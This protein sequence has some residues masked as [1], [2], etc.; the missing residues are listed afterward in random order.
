M[1]ISAVMPLMSVYRLPYGQLGYKGHIINLPQNVSAFASTLPRLPTELDIITVRKQGAKNTH[2]DF[3]VRKL[4]VLHALQWLLNN[5]KYYR[6]INL[7]MRA[8]DL[9]PHDGDITDKCT[10]VLDDSSLEQHASNNTE[11]SLPSLGSFIPVVARNSTEESTIKKNL[12]GQSNDENVI[13]V[14]Q[15]VIRHKQ[16]TNILLDLDKSYYMCCKLVLVYHSRYILHYRVTL[17]KN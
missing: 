3:R 11:E 8:I 16:K 12:T 9:L 14:V 13:Q 1:L 5:N 2:H 4:V 10:E 6:N 7:D 17:H 15:Y